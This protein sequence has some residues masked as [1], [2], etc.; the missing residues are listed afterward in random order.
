MKL[1]ILTQPL[2]FNY[3]GLLQAYALQTILERMGHEVI[4]LNRETTSAS[5][6]FPNNLVLDAKY[7]L[8]KILRKPNVTR[9]SRQNKLISSKTQKFTDSYLHTSPSL[10]SVKL[11][12]KYLSKHPQDGF[13]VGSDQVWRPSMSPCLTNYFLDFTKLQN[14]KRIAYAASFGV[15]CWEFTDA[16]TVACSALA[17]IF[18]AISVREASGVALC[19]EYLEVDAVHVLDPT[20]MLEKEDYIQLANEANETKIDGSLFC[21]VL[22]KS[23]EKQTVI[24]TISQKQGLK[25]FYCMPALHDSPENIERDPD[26][27][28]YPPVTQWLRSFMDAEMVLTDSFHG[29][30]FSIIF[31]K[32]FWVI[33][34]K[35]RGLSRFESILGIF[36]LQD[37][38]ITPEQASSIDWIAPIDWERVNAVRKEW[39]N[40]SQDFLDKALS[41]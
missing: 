27:C 18:D 20:L 41:V 34:N 5:V 12:N 33:G 7:F 2:F 14:V 15:D 30:A 23:E 39:Q 40:M 17:K 35:A 24:K 36:G 8:R 1:A 37:R 25:D 22:D 13:V 21:Y 26:N 4:I 3:G 29:T 11:L 9:N 19:E 32:P 28:I 16:D 31:N 6:R 38:L 10:Y